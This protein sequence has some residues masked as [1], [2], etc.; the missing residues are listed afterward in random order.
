MRVDELY[1]P[2]VP[3]IYIED[4]WITSTRGELARRDLEADPRPPTTQQVP[5]MPPALPQTSCQSTDGANASDSRAHL[6]P[7]LSLDSVIRDAVPPG[8]RRSGDG[9]AETFRTV[10]LPVL[11]CALL[12]A[13]AAAVCACLKEIMR[14]GPRRAGYNAARGATV[15]PSRRPEMWRILSATCSWA[16]RPSSRWI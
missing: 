1:L 8:G 16:V 15:R 4:D 6:W 5:S 7:V 12:L 14:R 11:L 2:P 9:G 3:F 13:A 10:L